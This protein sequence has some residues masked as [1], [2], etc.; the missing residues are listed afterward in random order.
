M[1]VR[2]IGKFHVAPAIA[3]GEDLAAST[4]ALL[5]AFAGY[6]FVFVGT[7]HDLEWHLKTAASRVYSHLWPA[8]FLWTARALAASWPALARTAGARPLSVESLHAA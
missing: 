5:L 8:L 4:L 7:H 1:P 3:F 2:A 6:W